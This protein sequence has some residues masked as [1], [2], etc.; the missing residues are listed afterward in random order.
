MFSSSEG[1]CE[2]NKFD[3]SSA[4]EGIAVSSKTTRQPCEDHCLFYVSYPASLVTDQS[5]HK[6]TDTSTI[7]YEILLATILLHRKEGHVEM[8]HFQVF[9]DFYVLKISE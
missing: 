9:L 7:W 2:L 6:R 3:G 4:A 1:D 5:L 8:I